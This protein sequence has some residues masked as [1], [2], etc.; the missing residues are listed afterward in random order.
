MT[1]ALPSSLMT[2]LEALLGADNLLVDEESLTFYSTDVYRQADYL[3]LA[4]VQPDIFCI[5]AYYQP[6]SF[7]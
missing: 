6:L 2:A 3:A 7:F 1:T 5:L 4:V